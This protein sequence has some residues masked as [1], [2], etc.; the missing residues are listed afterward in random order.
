MSTASDLGVLL[1]F[2]N[3][4]NKASVAT[5]LAKGTRPDFEDDLAEWEHPL[6]FALEEIDYPSELK[7][8]EHNQLHVAWYETD[9]QL[10]NLE[11]A[12]KQCGGVII[13]AYQFADGGDVEEL[14]LNAREVAYHAL[15]RR[16]GA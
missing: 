1:T 3:S 9:E 11:R 4:K 2:E 16:G 7:T 12:F 8:I 15:R 14:L 6:F 13:A 5:L 10:P